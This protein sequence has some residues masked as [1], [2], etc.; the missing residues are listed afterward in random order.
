MLSIQIDSTS[1]KN[2]LF[3][4]SSTTSNCPSLQAIW[5]RVFHYVRVFLDRCCT[6]IRYSRVVVI[7][8]FYVSNDILF[9]YIFHTC[10]IHV[11]LYVHKYFV[12]VTFL[13]VY[14]IPL[15]KVSHLHRDPLLSSFPP[16]L[17]E[18]SWRVSWRGRT[19]IPP[20][21]Q[22]PHSQDRT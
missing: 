14:G 1:F 21:W 17:G 3:T 4:I 18:K 22:N 20:G 9:C 8:I 7:Y 10:Q 11:V 16:I 13:I 5:N 6:V 2:W 15:R 19:L 12:V